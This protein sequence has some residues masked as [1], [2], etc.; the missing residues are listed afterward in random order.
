MFGAINNE[1]VEAFLALPCMLRKLFEKL[2]KTSILKKINAYESE[3]LT[4]VINLVAVCC[5]G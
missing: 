1:T 2:N 3:I 4:Y 5:R